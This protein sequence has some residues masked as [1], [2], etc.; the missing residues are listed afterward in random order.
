M[1]RR[2]KSNGY[3]VRQAL[4][5]L[6]RSNMELTKVLEKLLTCESAQV[7]SV[8]VAQGALVMNKRSA[9]VRTLREIL[10]EG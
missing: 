1:A 6:D 5:D 4:S 10:I 3:L 9:A 2:A 8:L 7:R